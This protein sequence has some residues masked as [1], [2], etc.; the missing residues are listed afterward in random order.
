MDMD[1]Y[2]LQVQQAVVQSQNL[3]PR[4]SAKAGTPNTLHPMLGLALPVMFP[5]QAVAAHANLQ[6]LPKRSGS[7][8]PSIRWSDWVQ[9]IISARSSPSRKRTRELDKS[10]SGS[11]TESSESIRSSASSESWSSTSD[12]ESERLSSP[13]SPSSPTSS[14]SSSSRWSDTDTE[15]DTNSRIAM[16]RLPDSGK[17]RCSRERKRRGKKKR[18]VG[19]RNWQGRCMRN[20]RKPGDTMKQVSCTV[21]CI[22][23][24]QQWTEG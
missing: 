11:E 7:F 18:D 8:T 10:S 14:S 9:M 22:T 16:Q 20:T 23:I 17:K 6:E 1:L 21:Q 3:F 24:E 19:M 4:G 2:H 15:T 13:S 5:K 12:S